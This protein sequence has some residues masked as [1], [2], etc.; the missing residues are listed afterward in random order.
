MTCNILPFDDCSATEHYHKPCTCCTATLASVVLLCRLSHSSRSLCAGE[1]T[2]IVLQVGGL[3]PAGQATGTKGATKRQLNVRDDVWTC[4]IVPFDS[5]TAVS[6]DEAGDLEELPI[7]QHVQKEMLKN[8]WFPDMELQPRS[9]M[10]HDYRAL[11]ARLK[12]KLSTYRCKT[13]MHMTTLLTGT[14]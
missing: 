7:M 2:F 6:T 14:Q 8:R 3:Q 13:S 12:S 10:F 4:C 9:P 5:D 11:A 1:L